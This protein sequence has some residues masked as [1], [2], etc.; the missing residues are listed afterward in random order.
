MQ[1]GLYAGPLTIG[2]EVVSDFAAIGFQSLV[3][4]PYPV[5][6]GEDALSPP[7]T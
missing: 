5:S 6:V 7:M 3:E 4:L 2:V 1:L